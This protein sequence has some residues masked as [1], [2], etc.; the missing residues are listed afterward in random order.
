[1]NKLINKKGF[2]LIELLIVVAIIGVLA[3]IVVVTLTGQGSKASDAALKSNLRSVATAVSNEAAS[4][5]SGFSQS[6]V[7]TLSSVQG[8][9]D[10][11]FEGANGVANDTRDG[12][13]RGTPPVA[14]KIY[15][16]PFDADNADDSNTPIGAGD[17][18][19]SGD[20]IR[21]GC[22]S[23]KDGWAVWGKLAEGKVFCLDSHGYAGTAKL[24]SS[25]LPAVFGDIDIAKCDDGADGVGQ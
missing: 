20:E 4:N 12:A 7:C 25:K 16:A 23:D 17:A 6:K 8:I 9:M 18:P 5:P 10:T 22:A 13:S 11:V 14:T 1:M 3:S 2:T 15:V 24:A 21:Y 19:V